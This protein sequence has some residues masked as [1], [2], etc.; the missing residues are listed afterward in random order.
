MP[1]LDLVNI[2]LILLYYVNMYCNPS[3]CIVIFLLSVQLVLGDS[4][5]LVLGE[6]V[7]LVLGESVQLV[8]VE[9]VQLVLGD[10]LDIDIFRL[11]VFKHL[12]SIVY[13]WILALW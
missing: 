8:L 10:I 1:L 7:Q 11:F 12:S 9:S 4:I 2:V 3:K 6:S 5:Q 13:F